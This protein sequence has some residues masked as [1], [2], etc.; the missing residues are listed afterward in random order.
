MSMRSMV[1]RRL[2]KTTP[3]KSTS[4]SKS[5]SKFSLPKL[6]DSFNI[7]P[8]LRNRSISFPKIKKPFLLTA[9]FPNTKIAFFLQTKAKF[10]QSKKIRAAGYHL[11]TLSPT[12]ATLILK[13]MSSR[14]V[15]VGFWRIL[16][17]LSRESKPTLVKLSLKK[18]QAAQPPLSV[19]SLLLP[20]AA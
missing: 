5:S 11:I 4:R 16:D 10:P 13:K 19:P 8:N 2:A 14:E 9:L 7:H 6:L 18:L 17:S 15:E 12:Q 20:S 3:K 1:A